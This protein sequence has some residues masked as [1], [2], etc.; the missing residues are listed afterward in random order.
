MPFDG[1]VKI[2]RVHTI[3][4]YDNSDVAVC[5]YDPAHKQELVTPGWNSCRCEACL[6]IVTRR[7]KLESASK[8]PVHT[9]HIEMLA[10]VPAEKA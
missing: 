8:I 6:K 9:S 4:H 7:I 3:H 10:R 1:W 2:A 5:G